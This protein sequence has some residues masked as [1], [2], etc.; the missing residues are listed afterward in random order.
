M[1]RSGV[2]SSSAPPIQRP[3][4]SK[5]IVSKT[6]TLPNGRVMFL[7]QKTLP[8]VG[9]ASPTTAHPTQSASRTH[10]GS[11]RQQRRPTPQQPKQT[12]KETK[13]TDRNRPKAVSQ[14]TEVQLRLYIWLLW[15]GSRPIR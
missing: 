6:I 13:E 7:Y 4:T 14:D 1:R 9:L 12:K 8:I 5:T 11:S 10:K 3:A 15:I 2:R